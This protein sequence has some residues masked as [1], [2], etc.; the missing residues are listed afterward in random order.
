M[1]IYH[2]LHYSYIF[3]P[4]CM[5]HKIK[6][7]YGTFFACNTIH[8]R[9]QEFPILPL[10]SETSEVVLNMEKPHLNDIKIPFVDDLP[11]PQKQM[12]SLGW[13]RVVKVEILS[14]GVTSSL[15]MVIAHSAGWHLLQS[16]VNHFESKRYRNIMVRVY[17]NA[18]SNDFFSK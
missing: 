1:C 12:L 9:T 14:F 3:S 4:L 6:K 15:E 16:T 5:W 17:L 18:N 7:I 13:W 11:N 2:L 8:I 10:N